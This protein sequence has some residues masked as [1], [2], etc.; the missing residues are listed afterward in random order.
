MSHYRSA[1]ARTERLTR[2]TDRVV[3][4]ISEA[5][6]PFAAASVRYRRNKGLKPG[7]VRMYA[8]AILKADLAL[9][10]R[11]F[12][13]ATPDDLA[14][15][16]ATMRQTLSERSVATLSILIRAAWKEVLEV[17]T[18]PRPIYRA[19]EVREPRNVLV[20]YVIP[21]PDFHAL[22]AE[23][24][25]YDGETSTLHRGLMLVALLWVLRSTGFRISE[26]LSLNLGDVRLDADGGAYY[27][28]RPD[29]P[30][31][32]T[33]PRTIYDV[34]SVAVVRAWMQMHPRAGDR[35]APLFIGLRDRT[36]LHRLSSLTALRVVSELAE[37]SGV[38]AKV[39]NG[40][41]ITPH[42]FR[43]TRATEIARNREMSEEEMRGYMGW[44]PG[45]KMPSTYI[46]LTLT[47]QKASVL[48]ASGI[49]PTG[50]PQPAPAPVPVAVPDLAAIAASLG[51][52]AQ[53][54]AG[55]Q[56]AQ[57]APAPAA[58]APAA[59]PVLPTSPLGA[60][61]GDGIGLVGARRPGVVA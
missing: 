15:V 26:A 22:L 27:A 1:S 55:A 11:P 56:A 33:G 59:A 29:A 50:I 51:Q 10:G 36:G 49:L 30:D 7:S 24:A 20:G 53:L 54:L 52:V 41:A 2:E 58:A 39:P 6:R 43:H 16:I 45:S 21:D 38:Q 19:L 57:A 46:H 42:D 3:A 25:A 48:R 23:A 5:N 8:N 17:E 34:R 14:A 32:K 44:S 28:L 61:T 13:E 40:D 9:G 12:R 4:R 18:L 35:S 47:D 31:L 37:A 60:W